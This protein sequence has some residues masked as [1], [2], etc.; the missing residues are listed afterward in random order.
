[1]AVCIEQRMINKKD[2][3][4]F[5]TKAKLE[6]DVFENHFGILWWIL[7]PLMTA[8]VYYV[9]FHVILHSGRENYIPFLFIGIV[10]WKWLASSVK[11][12]SNAISSQKNLFKKIYLPKIIFPWIEINF[13]TFKFLV[14]LTIVVLVYPL[15]GS[16]VTLNHLYLPLVVLCQFSFT[17]GI[18]TFLASLTPFFPDFNM[19]VNHLLK[20]A[21]YPSGI[22]FAADR[23]PRRLKFI[24]E[25]NPMAQAIESYRNILM[26]GSGPAFN[27]LF[28]MFF[29]GMF[30]YATGTLL[31][32]RLDGQYAK[33]P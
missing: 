20:L 27:G 32:N 11:A 7:D 22:L 10:A 8:F 1:M 14:T 13:A 3:I 23:V 9:V 33:L 28:L 19:M 12:G 4:L 25:Y 2:I 26:Y 21:F 17:L 31:I 15:L 5:Y 16:K 30:F 6:E 29:L 18:I 24:M